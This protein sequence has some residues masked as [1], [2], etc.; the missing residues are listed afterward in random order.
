LEGLELEELEAHLADCPECGPLAQAER[1][2]DSRLAQAMRAVSIPEEL[3]TRLLSKLETERKVQTRKRRRWIAVPAAAAALLLITW[4]GWTWLQKPIYVNVVEVADSVQEIN[5]NPSPSVLERHYRTQGIFTVAPTDANYQMFHNAYVGTLEG[6]RVPVLYF[7]DGKSK[8][9]VYIL[10]IKD[11][12]VAEAFRN[13]QGDGSGWKA[14]IRF[15]ASGD[16]G[17]LV[18]YLGEG[19]HLKVFPEKGG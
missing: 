9:Y 2:M 4:L 7:T 3:H 13:Q 19:E 6:K 15:D 17:Y 16:Y 8:A 18:I 5:F 10:R 11:F 1:Q 14:E 12:D